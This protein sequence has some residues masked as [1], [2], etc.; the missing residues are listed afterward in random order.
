M[1]FLRRH[2]RSFLA[3]LPLPTLG[4]A[5]SY[6][7]YRFALLFVP[8]WVAIV[9]AASFEATYIGLAVAQGLSVDQRRRA[10]YIGF[11]AVSVSIVYNSLDGLF[12]RRPELLTTMPLAGD[13]ALSVLHGLPLALV[14]YLVANLL[15]HSETVHNPPQSDKSDLGGRPSEYTLDELKRAFDGDTVIRRSDVVSR[16]GCSPTTASRLLADAVDEGWLSKNGVGY[17]VN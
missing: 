2:W 13:I 1:A 5:A 7:V 9:Q 4:L 14:A 3:H 17:L 8:S 15:L 11:G 6:G 16:L 12:H 10:Q